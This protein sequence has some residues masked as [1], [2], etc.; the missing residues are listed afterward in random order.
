VKFGSI[1]MHAAPT[2]L[3]VV[4]A[5]LTSD[6]RPQ[7]S[8]DL[9]APLSDAVPD[10]F[11]GMG[12]R[13]VVLSAREAE[14]AGVSDYLFR[15]Y[16]V[17]E[18]RSDGFS[19]YVGYYASQTHGKTIHSPKNCLPGSGWEALA[20]SPATIDLAAGQRATVNRYLLQ[21]EGQR[22]LVLYWYQGRGRVAHNEYAV[23]WYLLRDA[24]LRRR[25]EEA[26]VRIVVPVAASEEEAF[27]LARD[28]AAELIPSV[29]GAL[30]DAG[31]AEMGS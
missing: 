17:D 9:R 27:A 6:V 20:S 13:D 16:G 14:V 15:T 3:L 5:F 22:A 23:K 31:R 8:L 7:R 29:Q 19:I 24:A 18:A 11:A 26:L 30:P 2:A 28:V 25:S 12:G 4:G 1:R 10:T 21:N